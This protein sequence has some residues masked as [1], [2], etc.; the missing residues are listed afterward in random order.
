MTRNLS[1]FVRKFSVEAAK[2]EALPFDKIPGPRGF[3]G[4]G[5][6]YNYFK[7]FGELILQSPQQFIDKMLLNQANTVSMSFIKVD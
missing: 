5:N 1:N 6:F 3:L 2:N 4:I 7:V